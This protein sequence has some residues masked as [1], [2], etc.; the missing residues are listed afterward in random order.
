M[1]KTDAEPRLGA[2]QVGFQAAFK[3]IGG[4][5]KINLYVLFSTHL[6]IFVSENVSD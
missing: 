6:Y 4:G 2:A 1:Q 3:V 5:K